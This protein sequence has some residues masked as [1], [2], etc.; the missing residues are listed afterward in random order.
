MGVNDAWSN[1]SS[2]RQ[3]RAGA[4]FSRVADKREYRQLVVDT[5]GCTQHGNACNAREESV[6]A[7]KQ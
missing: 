6:K 5:D 2:S 4:E 7:C 3:W 1:G